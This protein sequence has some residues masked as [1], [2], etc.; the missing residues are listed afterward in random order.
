MIYRPPDKSEFIE[1]FDNSL[2]ESCISYIQEFYLMGDFN[3]NM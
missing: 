1:Y 2:K 3:I